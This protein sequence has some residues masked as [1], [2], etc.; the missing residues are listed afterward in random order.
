[1]KVHTSPGNKPGV[2]VFP[3]DKDTLCP[4]RLH[5]SGL[6]Q[7]VSFSRR[8]RPGQCQ[9]QPCRVGYPLLYPAPGMHTI[10]CRSLG[11][12]GDIIFILKNRSDAIGHTSGKVELVPFVFRIVPTLPFEHAGIK[13]IHPQYPPNLGLGK[14]FI[15]LPTAE[16][17]ERGSPGCQ[18]G[19]PPCHQYPVRF[20]WGK[21]LT[22][23]FPT[24]DMHRMPGM[25]EGINYFQGSISF[26]FKDCRDGNPRF[27][28]QRHQGTVIIDDVFLSIIQVFNAMFFQMIPALQS[29]LK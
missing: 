6:T 20:S 24:R 2:Q 8:Y 16:A 3:S 9:H 15:I 5:N 14:F 26:F 13:G 23:S 11:Y 4:N 27:T 12:E 25:K 21:K 28:L 1:M 17:A 10:L 19:I 22:P 29:P 18:P 7:R